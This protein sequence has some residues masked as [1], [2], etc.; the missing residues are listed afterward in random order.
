MVKSRQDK[1]WIGAV[2]VCLSVIFVALVLP[3]LV[4][5]LDANLSSGYVVHVGDKVSGTVTI[6]NKSGFDVTVQSNRFQPCLSFYNVMDKNNHA[7]PLLPLTSQTLKAGDKIVRPFEY[8]VTEAGIYLLNT[9]YSI[10]FN[11]YPIN[12][13]RFNIVI[14]L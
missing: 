13:F 9:H 14:V 12:T 2:G 3:V 1:V 8:E 4:L 6:T 10:E 5:P 11:G 7:E